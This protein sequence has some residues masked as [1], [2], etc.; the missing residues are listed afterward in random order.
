MKNAKIASERFKDRP[1]T[2]EQAVDY[3]IRYVVRH[4]GAP[5]LKSHTLNLPLYQYLFLDVLAVLLI[6]I[7]L[8]VLVMYVVLK[9]TYK[10]CNRI[11]SSKKKSK[12]E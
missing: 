9:F 1:M 10:Y 12:S 3:W 2:P 4:K 5:H 11:F 7:S 8:V 6:I